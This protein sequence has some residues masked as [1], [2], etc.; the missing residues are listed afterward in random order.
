MAAVRPAQAPRIAGGDIIIALIIAIGYSRHVLE[1]ND[2]EA[3]KLIFG[4]A[5]RSE[6]GS[7]CIQCW[8]VIQQECLKASKAIQFV[9]KGSESDRHQAEKVPARLPSCSL[10]L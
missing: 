2:S 7:C 8:E 9:C 3:A 1:K 10:L 6:G 4:E 5:L